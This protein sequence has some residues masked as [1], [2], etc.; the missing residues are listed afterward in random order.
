MGLTI[1]ICTDDKWGM[2]FFGKRQSRD[3]VLIKELCDSTEGKVCI[4]EYSLPLFADHKD[5]VKVGDD[6]VLIHEDG[7]VCFIEKPALLPDIES[8]DKLI[9]Y[10][11]C[12]V[13]PA[14]GRLGFIPSEH[15]T[16]SECSE[17][18]GS[19]HDVITKTV[20]VK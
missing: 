17:F 8:I 2:T 18:S 7:D 5:K 15:F 11:W 14:D 13:Y 20:Y 16:V 4:S 12:K 3:R 6:P 19:S 10:G 9:V 1:A